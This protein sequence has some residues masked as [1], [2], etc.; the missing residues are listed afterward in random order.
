M[1]IDINS[2][3]EKFRDSPLDRILARDLIIETKII[4]VPERS[5]LSGYIILSDDT[6]TLEAVAPDSELH[7]YLKSFVGK[8]VVLKLKGTLG[9]TEYGNMAFEIK[10]VLE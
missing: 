7:N 10:E 3:V 8:E 5:L 9:K 6:G 4:K 2:L 1:E